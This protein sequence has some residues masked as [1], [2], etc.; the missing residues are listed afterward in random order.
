MDAWIIRRAR[1]LSADAGHELGPFQ[2]AVCR[3]AVMA[4]CA[5]CGRVTTA[6]QDGTIEVACDCCRTDPHRPF[7]CHPIRTED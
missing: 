7:R 6:E 1:K 4:M 3:M 2:S 5:K